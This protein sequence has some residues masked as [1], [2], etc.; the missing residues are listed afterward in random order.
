[1]L[2]NGHYYDLYFR[3]FAQDLY[4]CIPVRELGI[5][6]RCLMALPWLRIFNMRGCN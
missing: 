2:D 5:M 4:R 3:S 1:M 6:G